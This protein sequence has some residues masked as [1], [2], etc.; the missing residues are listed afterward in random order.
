MNDVSRV[1]KVNFKLIFKNGFCFQLGEK[2]VSKP[3]AYPLV[4]FGTEKLASLKIVS[5]AFLRNLSGAPTC[6]VLVCHEWAS[7][8]VFKLSTSEYKLTAQN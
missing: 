6:P 7:P 3:Y 5:F 4:F 1:L 8:C 2:V